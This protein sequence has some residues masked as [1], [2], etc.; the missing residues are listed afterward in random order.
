[1]AIIFLSGE[2]AGVGVLALPGAMV[3]TGPAGLALLLYFTINAM[4]VGTR[5]GLCW[6]MVEERFPEYAE[7]CRDPYM[8]IAEKAGE[9][10]GPLA[11]KIFRQI[12]S[13]AVVLTLYGSCVLLIVLMATFL[14]NIFGTWDLD[15][16]KC[17][18]AL[19]VGITMMPLCW[20]GSPAD[21][22]FVAV[23]ALI[24]TVIGCI[25][26]MVKE[27]MDTSNSD[28]CYFNFT[29]DW[30]GQGKPGPGWEVNHPSVS[31]FTDFGKAFSSILFAFAGASTFP[32]IQ[33]DMKDRT[34]FPKAAVAAMFVLFLIY[35]PMSVVGWALLG[36]LVAGSVVESL[37]DGPIKVAVEIL[38][39]IHLITAFPILINPPCQLFENILNIPL[40]FGWKRIVFRSLVIALLIVIGLSV[41][42][43][44]VIVDLIGS[45]TIPI[46]N[47]IFPPFFYMRFVD[48]D[49]TRKI[50]TLMR[51]Y[52]WHMVVVGILGMGLSFYKAVL[53]LVEEFEHGQVPCWTTFF[54]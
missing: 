38:F 52:C 19:I 32:T 28:S 18:W 30:P 4:F 17:F 34:Q 39:L 29:E 23:G 16:N 48:S 36:D 21:F 20:L 31:N 9:T 25:M 27:G 6:I 41:P 13:T 15:L 53:S 3:N 54:E 33:A 47:F 45:T 2:M 40:T 8:V 1:M 42:F 7:N 22:W 49:K 10:M 5:L 51:V 11:A 12:T 35:M 24:S 44:G 26:I 43:F 46:L 50:S 37:C 14:E